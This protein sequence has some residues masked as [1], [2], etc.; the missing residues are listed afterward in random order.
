[1]AKSKHY[2]RISLELPRKTVKCQDNGRLG[3][4]SNGAPSGSVHKSVTAVLTRFILLF[5]ISSTDFIVSF[6]FYIFPSF[7]SLLDL[8]TCFRL[9]FILCFSSPTSLL[10]FINYYCCC[11]Y[12]YYYYYYCYYHYCYYYY[13]YYYYYYYYCCY[14]YS[15]TTTTTTTA[16][17][18]VAPTTTTIITTTVTLLLL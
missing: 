18:T 6:S 3:Q 8:V 15:I 7:T 17:A 2:P 14:C 16:A 5:S 4:D 11:C 10:H 1:V 12:Y 9:I 13:C